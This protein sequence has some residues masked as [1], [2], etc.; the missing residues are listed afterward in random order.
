MLARSVRAATGAMTTFEV[1]GAGTGSGQ[2][3]I[4]YSINDAGN[5]TGYYYDAR[6]VFHGFLLVL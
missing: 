2:G 6:D 1:P 5:V 3:T 4:A